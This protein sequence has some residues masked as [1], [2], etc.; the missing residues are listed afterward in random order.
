[1]PQPT[2]EKL[3]TEALTRSFSLEP[4]EDICPPWWPRLMWWLHFRPGHGPGPGPVNYPP[5]INDIMASLHIHTM[6]YLMEDQS[7]AQQIRTITEEKLV[8]S[9]KNLSKAH[10]EAKKKSQAA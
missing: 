10:A 4:G 9:V 1:M 7:A 2:R 8:N 6:S 3:D 5:A